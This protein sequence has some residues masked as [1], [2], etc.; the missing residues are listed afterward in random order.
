MASSIAGRALFD[1]L[2]QVVHRAFRHKEQRHLDMLWYLWCGP[3]SPLFG[4]DKISTFENYFVAEKEARVETKNP[5][6]KLIHEK[7][8]CRKILATLALIPSA[9]S[10]STA[11]FR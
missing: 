2:S 10:S 7:G 5:Y 8:F 1:A 3:L 4:K 9:G 6:F 11:T